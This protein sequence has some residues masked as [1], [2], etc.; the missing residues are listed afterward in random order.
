MLAQVELTLVAP[1]AEKEKPTSSGPAVPLPPRR[2]SP[3]ARRRRRPRFCNRTDPITR[4]R[5]RGVAALFQCSRGPVGCRRL[6][7]W[8]CERPAPV[9]TERPYLADSSRAL[10][11][12]ETQRD[13]QMPGSAQT[14][15]ASASRFSR[16]PGESQGHGVLDVGP[17]RSYALLAH[18]RILCWRT[19]I[20]SD[21]LS[22][23]TAWKPRSVNRAPSWWRA[24]SRSRRIS[25]LPVR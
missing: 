16:G 5:R 18:L 21:P 4:R 8:R 20:G 6:P 2:R 12:G 22:S 9:T 23:T 19:G 1:S 7:G 11:G 17:G 25:R 10:R 13:H 15:I 14:G 24:S 3:V